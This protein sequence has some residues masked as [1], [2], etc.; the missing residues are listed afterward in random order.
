MEGA[1]RFAR[2]DFSQHFPWYPQSP[3][4]AFSLLIPKRP[5]DVWRYTDVQVEIVD[6]RGERTLLDDRWIEWK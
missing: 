5:K 4:P 6:G 2:A 3:R 1:A